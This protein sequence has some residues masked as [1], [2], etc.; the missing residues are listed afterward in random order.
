MHLD[1]GPPEQM[2]NM[3]PFPCSLVTNLFTFYTAHKTVYRNPKNGASSWCSFGD[4]D[5]QI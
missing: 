4:T 1:P 5:A 2:T 3:G